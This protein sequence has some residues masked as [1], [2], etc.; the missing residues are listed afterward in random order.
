[1]SGRIRTALHV[2]EVQVAF[3]AVLLDGSNNIA[4][5]SD[6][7]REIQF[8]G[9]DVILRN[10]VQSVFFHID[11]GRRLDRTIELRIVKGKHLDIVTKSILII[12]GTFHRATAIPFSTAAR[13]INGLRRTV[14][15]ASFKIH[16]KRQF[17]V[18]TR[19]RFDLLGRTGG[20]RFGHQRTRRFPA[21]DNLVF[22]FGGSHH[23]RGLGTAHPQGRD[24]EQCN[25]KQPDVT[26]FR[27]P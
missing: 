20:Y 6:S 13:K 19:C 8:Q 5:P 10:P 26:H 15:R 9:V 18:R 7:G 12:G 3:G 17:I 11:N 27:S 14:A 16:R 25:D 24:T 4:E 21:G 23:L 1:M 22:F 2:V